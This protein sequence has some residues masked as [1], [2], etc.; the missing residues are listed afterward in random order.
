MT[1]ARI[2]LAA[3]L[4]SACDVSPTANRVAAPR[5]AAPSSS[6]TVPV[7]AVA[8]AV[9]T[10]SVLTADGWGP[11]AV[12]MT[13]AQ[14]T[15]A[16]GPDADPDAV[17]GAEPERCDQFRPARAPA[18]LLVMVEDGRLSRISLINDSNIVTDRGFGL[19]AS[20]SAVKAAYGRAAVATPHKYSDAPAEYV[21]VWK[22]GPRAPDP[23]VKP[24]AR[25][26]V[27]EVDAQGRVGMIH[28]GGPSI[29]YI[30]G[31]L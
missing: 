2:L 5:P 10:V 23:D 6:R 13:M 15:A 1:E 24:S 7:D 4:V 30:E 27:Y 19:G 29:Q 20:A 11:L 8:P 17:G 31:C 9:P 28:A 25:G 14:I 16:L 21:T 18:G 12:G 22:G 26:I 3:L